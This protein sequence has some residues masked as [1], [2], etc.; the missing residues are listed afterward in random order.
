MRGYKGIEEQKERRI[1]DKGGYKMGKQIV[2]CFGG[3]SKNVDSE[4][5]LMLNE[6]GY[7]MN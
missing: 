5:H 1:S 3:H 4:E 7:G 6:I 2:K